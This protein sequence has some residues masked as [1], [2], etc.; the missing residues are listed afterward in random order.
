MFRHAVTVGGL[1]LIALLA[2]ALVPAPA[3]ADDLTGVDQILCS[4]SSVTMC[5]SD[6]DCESGSPAEV[7]VPQFI[8]IDLKGRRLST[9]PAS[10]EN[11]S[12]EILNLKRGEGHI[13]L[14]GYENGRAFSFVIEEA[15]GSV[16]VAVAA[17]G[18]SVAVFGACT[19]MPVSR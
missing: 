18:R 3:R 8:Q 15:T 9:T 6:G 4:A 10:G 13:I 19:P 17:G 1:P 2:L 16:S 7:N 5:W 11:R 12:T 14:Q